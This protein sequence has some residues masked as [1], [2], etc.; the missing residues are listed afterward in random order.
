[1]D[2]LYNDALRSID[3]R[4]DIV[5]FGPGEFF[6]GPKPADE[7]VKMLRQVLSLLKA[8]ESGRVDYPKWSIVIKDIEA[9][10]GKP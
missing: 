1:M 7:P 8:V 6:G 4:G 10:L 3:A 9:C 5:G 2:E